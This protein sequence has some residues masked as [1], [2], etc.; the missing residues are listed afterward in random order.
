[1]ANRSREFS[2]ATRSMVSEPDVTPTIASRR[3]HKIDEETDDP[4]ASN[5][6]L[7]QETDADGEDENNGESDILVPGI[8]ES[9]MSTV[10]KA[11]TPRSGSD[12]EEFYHTPRAG[13]S[14]MMHLSSAAR[15]RL[16]DSPDAMPGA[17]LLRPTKTGP[18][19]IPHSRKISTGTTLFAPQ[20]GTAYDS[21]TTNPPKGSKNASAKGPS[22]GGTST[23]L[24][25]N[26][27]SGQRTPKLNPTRAAR[28]VMPPR[29]TTAPTGGVGGMGMAFMDIPRGARKPSFNTRALDLA[30][31]IGDNKWGPSGGMD[32]GGIS[33]M[34]NSF[35]ERLIRE[36]ELERQ[37]EEER[38]QNEE[39]EK[40]MVN[41]IMLARMHTLEEGFREVLKEI[42]D[43]SRSNANSSRRDSE[44]ESR[45]PP[46]KPGLWDARPK[47]SPRKHARHGSKGKAITGLA[48]AMRAE[49]QPTTPSPESVKSVIERSRDDAD[50]G[51]DEGRP[52]TAVLTP[53]V[54]RS[55]D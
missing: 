22:T 49:E 36:R 39:E 13:K 50:A 33:G 34:P 28:P 32:I 3:P 20:P 11:K 6:T 40:G 41:R 14:P 42:K 46:K 51:A 25:T 10:E 24:R 12:D 21:S 43:L 4:M 5:E 18:K 27:L 1:M 52:G 31:D 47:K 55:G 26:L 19:R 44:V 29:Q 9:A 53:E 2:L 35:S 8:G 30:S 48:A 54:P 16:L 7:P 23:P 38:R 17:S 37:R 45:T 15:S